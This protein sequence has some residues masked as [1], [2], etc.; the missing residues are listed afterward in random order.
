MG[1]SLHF[2]LIAN[3]PCEVYIDKKWVP[4]ELTSWPVA[5]TENS[6][7]T[8]KCR[9]YSGN[10]FTLGD[11]ISVTY[12]KI[13]QPKMATW[14]EPIVG[15][16]YHDTKTS[17]RVFARTSESVQLQILP[18]T[19]KILTQTLSLNK[20]CKPKRITD[21]HQ[22]HSLAVPHIVGTPCEAYIEGSSWTNCTL[23]SIETYSY[24][25][26]VGTIQC[27]EVS[28]LAPIG[29]Y[30]G[31]DDNQTTPLLENQI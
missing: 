9:K 20:A 7:V 13:R 3:Y 4:A 15:A 31:V 26:T 8:V 11:P 22:L 16:L 21:I 25:V 6:Q 23:E 12:K 29:T 24:T 10:D 30:R 1:N 19:G 18:F 27:S 17:Y 14:S 2:P 28:A 5:C